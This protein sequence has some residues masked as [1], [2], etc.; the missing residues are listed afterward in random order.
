MWVNPG[1]QCP[2]VPS[3]EYDLNVKNNIHLRI[4]HSHKKHHLNFKHI[5]V[6]KKKMKPFTG[7]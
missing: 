1:I 3:T 4:I 7:L 2:H 6:Y 5:E